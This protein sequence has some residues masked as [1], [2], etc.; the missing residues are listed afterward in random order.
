VPAPALAPVGTALEIS[1][2]PL[3]F[4]FHYPR[5]Y[6]RPSP[7]STHIRPL[8][9]RYL[10]I[11]KTRYTRFST[12]PHCP[13]CPGTHSRSPRL[14]HS[15]ARSGA[16]RTKSARIRALPGR[17][18]TPFCCLS[19]RVPRRATGDPAKR[20]PRESVENH[21]F[22]SLS[23]LRPD[24]FAAAAAAAKGR[25][26]VSSSL[27]SPLASRVAPLPTGS[28]HS[29]RGPSLELGLQMP[30]DSSV[31]EM[32]AP[33][34]KTEEQQERGAS[35]SSIAS[36]PEPEPVG[37]YTQENTEHPQQQKRKGGRKP[38]RHPL[39][40]CYEYNGPKSHTHR[41]HGRSRHV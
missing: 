35:T 28:P 7:S 16:P 29:R 9:S 23:L 37:T 33:V 17:I 11:I 3:P 41:R 4:C 18:S 13:L 8:P 34:G 22:P 32:T 25:R 20:S 15:T 24:H 31:T 1:A 39:F 14:P 19:H 36:S 12:C 6:L 40:C 2:A 10:T 21:L 5:A 30:E 38:V 26:V 27:S